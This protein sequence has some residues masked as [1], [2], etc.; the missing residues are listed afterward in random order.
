MESNYIH[1]LRAENYMRLQLVE[2]GFVGGELTII[3]GDNGEGKSS[4]L[5]SIFAALGGKDALPEKPVREGTDKADIVLDLGDLMVRLRIMPDRSQTLI[6]ES[7]DGARYTSPQSI[8]DKM[9]GSLT[10]DPLGFAGE[11]PKKQ[12]EVLRKLVKLDTSKVDAD[13]NQALETRRHLHKLADA[14]SA[15][16]ISLEKVGAHFTADE[17]KGFETRIEIS[18]I[19]EAHQAAMAQTAEIDRFEQMVDRGREDLKNFD[20]AIE[21]KRK[22]IA[23]L[24]GEIQALETRRQKATTFIEE[25][26]TKILNMPVPNTAN[27]AAEVKKAEVHNKNAQWLVSRQVAH[28]EA[29]QA[30]N[31]HAEANER[32]IELNGEKAKLLAAAKFP[33]EG[34]GVEGDT[35]T[36]GG[37]PLSQASSAEQ[38]RVCLSIAAALNP[39]L[40]TILVHQGNDLDKKRMAAIAEWAKA[41]NYQ[42]IMERVATD[43]PVGV[44]IEAGLIKEDLRPNAPAKPELKPAKTKVKRKLENGPAAGAEAEKEDPSEGFKAEDAY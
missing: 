2:L 38:L 7:K 13:I 28:G 3:S 19:A 12:A 29:I 40:R 30:R 18:S 5:G 15:N 20:Q 21:E 32:V 39:N 14:A 17:V 41:N 31:R 27:L 24:E 4:L 10:F 11:E 9:V 42:I 26:S 8:L 6:V 35:V 34:L 22:A 36:F 44:V 16:H 25:T 33:I 23:R 1:G 43:T 37:L